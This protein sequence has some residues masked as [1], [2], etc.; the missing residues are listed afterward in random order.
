ML[1]LSAM[2]RITVS[3]GSEDLPFEWATLE[4]KRDEYVG[5]LNT[6]YETNLANDN[7]ECIHGR[8]HFTFRNE[9]EVERDEGRKEHVKSNHV[10]LQLPTMP[11]GMGL[12]FHGKVKNPRT[13]KVQAWH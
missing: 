10:L 2:Q 11:G 8:A 1:I 7:V 13:N 6:A 5:R 3:D 9:V 12:T 4:R